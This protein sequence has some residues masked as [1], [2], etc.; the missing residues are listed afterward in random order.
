MGSLKAEDI[1]KLTSS[2]IIT[3]LGV[4]FQVMPILKSYYRLPVF[5]S[6]EDD[7]YELTMR[8]VP[9]MLSNRLN[10][11]TSRQFIRVDGSR[12]WLADSGRALVAGYNSRLKRHF[13]YE[14]P[15]GRH[16]KKILETNHHWDAFQKAEASGHLSGL[17]AEAFRIMLDGLEK[18][19]TIL[20]RKLNAHQLIVDF[21]TM[22]PL[23]RQTPFF[24]KPYEP[25][26]TMEVK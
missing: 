13:E 2:Q 19:E 23:S 5:T 16:S 26:K 9:E 7:T 12:F 21:L 3:V 11:L 4:Y 15:D 10:I 14:K 1:R 8:D 17:G 25:N 20:R 24:L 22:V 6:L 18:R